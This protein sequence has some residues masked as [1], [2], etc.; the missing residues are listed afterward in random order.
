MILKS[1]TP[2]MLWSARPAMSSQSRDSTMHPSQSRK[3]EAVFNSFGKAA[4]N[5]ATLPHSH[6]AV[7]FSLRY[8]TALVEHQDIGGEWPHQN[9]YTTYARPGW[10]QWL[11][12]QVRVVTPMTSTQ[13]CCL[14]IFF[15]AREREREREWMAAPHSAPL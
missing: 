8:G 2:A 7:P 12:Y 3:G 13:R 6:T 9:T 5:L 10:E 14:C 4:E 15:A 11:P 1:T